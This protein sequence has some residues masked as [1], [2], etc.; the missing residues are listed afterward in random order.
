M[1]HPDTL[2][3]IVD[4][5]PRWIDGAEGIRRLRIFALET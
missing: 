3:T 5:L 2:L 1:A 4:Q